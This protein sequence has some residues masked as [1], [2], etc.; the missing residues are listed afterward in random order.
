MWLYI[1]IIIV[2]FVSLVISIADCGNNTELQV[3]KRFRI[4][5]SVYNILFLC[6]IF[7]FW[8]L[9][10]FRGQS[11]GN[12]TENYLGFYKEIAKNGVNKEALQ[13]EIVYQYLCLIL[14]K[15]SANPLT[16]LI[17]SATFCYVV[18]GIYI[19]K[20]S[21]NVLF[22][23]LLL[24]CIAFSFF[25]S[26]IRQ[27]IAMSIVLIAYFQI[28]DGKKILP[29]I[30]I[31]FATCFHKSALITI[32]WFAHR[33]APKKPIV[34]VIGAIGVAVLALTGVLN[35]IL[36][37]I[38]SEYKNYFNSEN[39]GSGRLGI[40]YYALR[41]L[42]FYY[43]IYLAGKKDFKE[44]SIEITNSILLLLTVCL[45]FSVNLFNR[46]ASYFLL[47]M[48][49]DL[50]NAFNSGEIKHR[51]SLMFITGSVMLVYFVVTLIFRPE[52][53]HLYPYEFYW[54]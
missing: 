13:I 35:S 11:I 46:A 24:F 39:A 3:N 31:L 42:V 12:D 43:P 29:L 14:S 20:K 50:P 36:S 37:I 53:N 54:G 48:V 26:G 5:S 19:Y 16:I 7:L 23:T 22:S 25:M 51:K 32:L 2:L 18:C 47:P 15:I 17:V 21:T 27:A 6:L 52:W 9:T 1:C 49:F 45:G 30:L 38:L 40:T 34:V 33:F 44:H 28:K 10:A 8:F 4:N 41:A